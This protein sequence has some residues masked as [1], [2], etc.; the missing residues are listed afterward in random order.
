MNPRLHVDGKTQIST[1]TRETALR[2][3]G[4]A[5]AVR[6]QAGQ[7]VAILRLTLQIFERI[8]TATFKFLTEMIYVWLFAQNFNFAPNFFKM[9]VFYF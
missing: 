9:G 3:S 2:L 5:A 7:K 1:W 8:P 6:T 4:L